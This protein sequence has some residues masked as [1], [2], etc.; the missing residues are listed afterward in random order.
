MRCLLPLPVHR[1]GVALAGRRHGAARQARAPRKSASPSRRAAPAR[2]HRARESRA[3]GPRRPGCRRPPPACAAAM[4][5]GF[6]R[7]F[8]TFGARTAASAPT[9]PLPLRSRNRANERTPARARISDRLPAPSARRAAMKARTSCG[10]SLASRLKVGLPPRCSARNTRNWRD[11]TGIGL[12][13]LARHAPLGRKMRRASAPSRPRHPWR[14]TSIFLPVLHRGRLW[15]WPH[16]LVGPM[17]RMRELPSAFLN[18]PESARP[19]AWPRNSSMFWCRSRSTR[20]IPT[21]SRRSSICAGRHRR[22]AARCA[23]GDRRGLGRGRH[24]PSPACTTG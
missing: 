19:S 1:D 5:S 18:R 20:P 9:L 13:G 7:V 17:R 10:A 3:R 11:I 22:R 12:D 21:G 4:C 14:Q 6:G 2:R 23:R 24:D 15:S 16:Y 8:A